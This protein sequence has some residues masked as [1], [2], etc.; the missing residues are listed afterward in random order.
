MVSEHEANTSKKRGIEYFTTCLKKVN[1]IQMSSK[2]CLI[3]WKS[4]T[5]YKFI[6]PYCMHTYNRQVRTFYK[7]CPVCLITSGAI[8]YGVPLIDLDPVVVT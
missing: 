6:Y 5:T 8:Q 1:A 4:I 7:V 2:T 3:P